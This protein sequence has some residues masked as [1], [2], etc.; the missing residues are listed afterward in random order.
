MS[1]RILALILSMLLLA[2][3]ACADDFPSLEG[4][5]EVDFASLDGVIPYDETIAISFARPVDSTVK[6]D[7]NNPK[8]KSYTE[9]IW[10]DLFKKALNIELSYK[11]VATDADSNNAK[12]GAAIASGDLPDAA[13]VSDVVYKQLQDAGLIADMTDLYEA[14]SSALYKSLNTPDILGNLT[15][16]GRLYGLPI[17]GNKYIG[18]AVLFVRSD[19]LEK[20]NL[21]APKTIDDVI[22][23]A[24][25]FKEA[26]LGGED[27]IGLMFAD[28]SAVNDGRLQGFMNGYGAYRNIWVDVDGKL[29]WSNTLP[30]MREALLALQALYAEGLIN[31]DFAVTNGTVAQE[32]V[33]SGKCGIFYSTDYAVTM[34]MEAAVELD[35]E[36]DYICVG[37]P[38]LTEDAETI[39]QTGAIKATKLFVNAKYEHP[40]AVLRMINLHVV[41]SL[42]DNYDWYNAF[43][44]DAVEGTMYYKF[45]PW[46]GAHLQSAVNDISYANDVRLSEQAGELIVTL[47]ENT[48]RVKK[49]WDIQ[50]GSPW[51]YGIIGGEGGA[52]TY[53]Y[54]MFTSG[55][56]LPDAFNTL[57]TETMDMLGDIVNDALSTAMLEV[58][59]GA[60][61][62]VYDKAVEDWF[63]NGGQAIT[64]EVNEWY[65]SK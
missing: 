1:K 56:M 9:N 27:T 39:I 35:P 10:T 42:T 40:E 45:L 61:I 21:E 30:E 59:M 22:A 20:L 15:T 28:G 2:G 58:I 33:A 12:W 55:R 65:A 41:L 47:P 4:T 32:Y 54:D 5:P 7:E 44:S 36:A 14:E 3:I 11:W 53:D 25:A 23:V 57:P 64:D 34:S 29:A 50:E 6:I 49:F 62:S 13:V 8:I 52:Y 18:N 16:G 37:I 26:K 31:E 48:S 51:W 60:D 38:G 17:P 19:W 24:R 43:E 46:N 63:A